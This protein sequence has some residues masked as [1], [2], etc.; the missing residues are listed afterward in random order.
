MVPNSRVCISNGLMDHTFSMN[1][2]DKVAMSKVKLTEKKI[3]SIPRY[4]TPSPD[5]SVHLGCR[6]D[7]VLVYVPVCSRQAVEVSVAEND[8]TPVFNKLEHLL[9]ECGTWL[10]AEMNRQAVLKI[11]IQQTDR[12]AM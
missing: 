4:D 12:S 3:R 6:E 8:V 11:C 5:I 2:R 7:E 9:R 1:Q 10:S